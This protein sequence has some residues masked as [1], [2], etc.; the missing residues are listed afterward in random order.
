MPGAGKRFCGPQGGSESA[1]EAL[2]TP[3]KYV[4]VRRLLRTGLLLAGRSRLP[5]NRCIIPSKT[6]MSANSLPGPRHHLGSVRGASPR[7]QGNR[8]FLRL[9]VGN[10][11]GR[12]FFAFFLRQ[13]TFLTPVSDFYQE[14]KLEPASTGSKTEIS[15]SS[16]SRP[17]L[18]AVDKLIAPLLSQLFVGSKRRD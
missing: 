14:S 5:R 11:G 7:A 13:T 12:D 6:P 2:A 3:E 16:L 4:W 9:N 17:S 15:L 10:K 1:D 8:I 18:A